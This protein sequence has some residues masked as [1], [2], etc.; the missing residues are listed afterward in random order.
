MGEVREVKFRLS[1]RRSSVPRAR[2]LAHSVLGDWGIGQAAHT[3]ELVLSEL[4]TNAM[5][6][7]AP[8]DRLVGVRI[9]WLPEDSLLRLEVSDAGEGKPE[10]RAP[11]EDETGGRGLLLVEALA[12][13]WGFEQRACGIGKTVWAELRAPDLGTGRDGT[14]IAAV[15]VREGQCVR[16]WGAWRTVRGVGTERSASG[17]SC[18]VVLELDDGFELRV[19]T[20]A[21]LTVREPGAP[22]PRN[23]GEG[24][25]R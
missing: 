12:D 17:G 13:R 25:S 7:R 5:R 22:S 19:G 6:V 23:G 9:A 11:D 4:V 10:V 3:A 15:A 14:E 21:P 2:A 20:D 24:A 16:V 8:R 18:T 1:R